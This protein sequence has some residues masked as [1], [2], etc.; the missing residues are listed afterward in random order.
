MVNERYLHSMKAEAC[1]N[2]F[3]RELVTSGGTMEEV[4]KRAAASSAPMFYVSYADARKNVSLIERGKSLLKN[5]CKK[6]MYEELHRRWKA[7]GAKDYR[8]LEDIIEKKAPGFYLAFDSFRCL[9]YKELRK[10]NR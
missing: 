2:A 10:R 9:V 8:V 6:A 5:E 7:T 4:F 1:V 3:E